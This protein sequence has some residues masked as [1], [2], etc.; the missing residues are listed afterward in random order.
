M[1]NTKFVRQRCEVCRAKTTHILEDDV[2]ICLRC[3]VRK[4]RQ[5]EINFLEED[6]EEKHGNMFGLQPG[7]V[8][9]NSG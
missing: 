3:D 2:Q 9:R 7:N 8:G 6:H 1:S 4:L 5:L